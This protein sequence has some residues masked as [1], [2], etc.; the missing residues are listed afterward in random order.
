MQTEQFH[1]HVGGRRDFGMEDNLRDSGDPLQRT[2]E[3]HSDQ[4]Q[5]VRTRA[6]ELWEQE[7]RPEGR[8]QIHWSQAEQELQK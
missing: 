1:D 6:Y 5:R 4:Q 2:V 3:M 7:G 8:D